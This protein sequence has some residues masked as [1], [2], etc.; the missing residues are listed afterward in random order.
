M[1]LDSLLETY[2]TGGIAAV[3]GK[4]DEGSSW[5]LPK[6]KIPPSVLKVVGK[7]DSIDIS[8]DDLYRKAYDKME[9]RNDHTATAFLACKKRGDVKGALLCCLIEAMHEITGGMPSLLSQFRLQVEDG[10]V[11]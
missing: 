9:D 8:T 2:R 10:K 1:T 5:S 4:L 11:S 7:W 3:T 6:D